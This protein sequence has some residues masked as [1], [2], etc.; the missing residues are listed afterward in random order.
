MVEALSRKLEHERVIGNLSGI[1]I[2]RGVKIINHSQFTDDTIL[3]GGACI[4][5]ASRFKLVLDFFISASRGKVNKQK[6]Q[7]FGWNA[8]TQLLQ[9]IS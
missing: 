1:N 3:I 7:F 6:S 5:I 2:V 9:C 4:I 8:S